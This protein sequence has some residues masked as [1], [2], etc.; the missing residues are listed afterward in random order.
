MPQ[1]LWLAAAG[2][3]IGSYG[4]L[5]GAGGGFIL[6][7]LLLLL[8]PA[9]SADTI[10]TISLAVVFFNALSG[11]IAYARM[12]RVDY[13]SGVLFSTATVP[14]AIVGAMTTSLIPR[15]PFDIIV[16][17]LLLGIS[18]VL[19]ARPSGGA[20]EH[21]GRLSLSRHLVEADG[22]VHLWSYDPVIGV[23]ISLMVGFVSSVLGIGG[24]FIHVPVM[25]N[26]LNFPV[27]VAAATS[28]FTLAVMT[29]VASA[30]HAIEGS[31]RGTWDRVLPLAVG[32]VIGA[33]LGARLARVVR[34]PWI[35]RALTLALVFVGLRLI[36]KAL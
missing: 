21:H 6:V 14:G 30:V 3:V 10:A 17:V 28:H 15:R 9:E 25:V 34:G 26:L 18:I 24:G 1:A 8:Y 27:H 5:I 33:Q 23:G 31:L 22:T 16:G 2:L 19:L 13:G 20:A 32:V 29:A 35:L 12:R 7:P 11:T 36:I 4:T